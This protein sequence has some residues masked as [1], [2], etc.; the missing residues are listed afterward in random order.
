MKTVLEWVF[1][2]STQLIF[3]FEPA[4]NPRLFLFFYVLWKRE[5]EKWT[6]F[7]P[8]NI[9]EELSKFFKSSKGECANK[10]YWLVC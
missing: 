7:S 4:P 3:G 9:D 5:R 8:K 6:F 2:L 1:Y 10:G